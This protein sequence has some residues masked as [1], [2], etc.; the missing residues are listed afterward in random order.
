MAGAYLTR[1]GIDLTRASVDLHEAVE[2]V[3]TKC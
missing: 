1:L 3:A 2:Q